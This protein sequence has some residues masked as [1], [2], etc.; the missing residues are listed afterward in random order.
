MMLGAQLHEEFG[1]H[2]VNKSEKPAKC[3]ILG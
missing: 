3:G 1:K 2:L